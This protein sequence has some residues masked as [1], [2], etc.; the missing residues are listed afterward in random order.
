MRGREYNQKK[1]KF[2][3]SGNYFFLSYLVRVC[4]L[5]GHCSVSL[6]LCIRGAM[7]KKTSHY[8]RPSALV[9]NR[10]KWTDATRG[11]GEQYFRIFSHNHVP[12]QKMKM[13]MGAKVGG[14]FQGIG[15]ELYFIDL[16]C[17]S[18]LETRPKYAPAIHFLNYV[19][20]AR[21]PVLL[22]WLPKLFS[23]SIHQP[24]DYK[25]SS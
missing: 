23:Y 3:C 22:V 9:D 19:N 2:A 4:V 13:G 20:W 15:V 12:V 21:L 18:C 10:T 14:V 8:V 16:D 25:R 5:S 1:I 24:R 6:V 11:Q 7:V 17:S